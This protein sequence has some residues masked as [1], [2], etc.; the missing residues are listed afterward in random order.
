MLYLTT[1]TVF[2]FLFVSNGQEVPNGQEV[3]LN[4]TLYIRTVN[5]VERTIDFKRG[6]RDGF[7]TTAH[8]FPHH[9]FIGCDQPD[10]TVKWCNGAII[11]QYFVA[12]LHSCL[13]YCVDVKIRIGSTYHPETNRTDGHVE[14]KNKNGTTPRWRPSKRGI[15][16]EHDVALIET[17]VEILFT[18][19]IQ[20]VRL[21]LWDD[22]DSDYVIGTEV[23]ATAFGVK[24]QNP[25]W[26]LQLL[27]M[28]MLSREACLQEIPR[29]GFRNGTGC[30][31]GM[32]YNRTCRGSLCDEFGA[33]FVLKRDNKTLVGLYETS[34]DFCDVGGPEGFIYIVPYVDWIKRQISQRG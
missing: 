27:T 25:L 26:E 5:N 15:T 16:F 19:E 29:L 21:P 20:P 7:K 24:E 3:L 6:I 22:I 1:V 17:N 34:S 33:P 32:E 18:S 8:E 10:G 23:V 4:G 30:A 2:L 12:T 28:T 14:L 9:A 31:A 13:N 11:N